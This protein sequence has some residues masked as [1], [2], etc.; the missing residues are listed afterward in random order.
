MPRK[1]IFIHFFLFFLISGC[2][3]VV[4][5][6]EQEAKFVKPTI[7]VLTFENRA[8][9]MMQSQLGSG[10]AEQLTERLIATKRYVVIERQYFSQ[11][12]K[13]LNQSQGAMF[14][15]QGRLQMGQLKHVK[16]LIRGVITDFGYVETTHG[17]G[18]VLGVFGPISYDVVAATLTVVDVQT[19]QNVASISVEGKAKVTNRQ[20]S[21]K[22]ANV[23]FGG[24]AFYKTTLGK[25]TNEMLDNA[26]REIT[27]VLAERKFHPK[28]ARVDGSMLYI[29]GGE[30]R[31]INSG[32]IYIVRD[33]PQSVTDPDT[34]DNLGSIPGRFIGKVQILNVSEKFS[35]GKILLGDS[36]AE[37]QV[38][39]K[40]EDD[41]AYNPNP[42]PEPEIPFLSNDES[43]DK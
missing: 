2:S 15:D 3:D 21:M 19:G 33:I 24:H 28:V 38:L 14:R 32:D 35:Y 4:Y 13:E 16:Y 41:P 23:A 1:A 29:T 5:T 37:G 18:R 12:L 7:A 11:I 34:G 39:Y 20:G 22:D 9:A 26:V 27:Q 36:F 42:E 17:L 25:A 30:D 40:P 6:P 8:P 43:E 10:M 31:M